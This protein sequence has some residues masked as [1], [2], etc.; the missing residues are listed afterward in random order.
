MAQN[1][2]HPGRQSPEHR[3]LLQ[4]GAHGQHC[5]GDPRRRRRLPELQV[6][7]LHG[8][9]REA[10]VPGQGAQVRSPGEQVIQIDGMKLSFAAI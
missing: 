10:E 7:R 8:G 3:L 4:P 2:G 5:S 6:R 9:V 1:P